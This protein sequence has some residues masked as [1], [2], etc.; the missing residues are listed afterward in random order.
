[1]SLI[2]DMLRNIEAK[3]PDDP[4]R[5]N[6]QR[7]I[8]SLPAAPSG[9][10]RWLKLLLL[11]GVPVLGAAVLHANGQL[12]PLLGLDTVQYVAPVPAV[13]PPP[14]PALAPTAVASPAVDAA[15]VAESDLRLASNLAILPLPAEP[16]LAVPDPIVPLAPTPLAKAEAVTA[17]A[18]VSSPVAASPAAPVGPVKIEKSPVLATPR[19][20]ADAEYRKAENALAAG[21]SA[22]AV[23]GLK[24]ALKQDPGYVQVRQM[25]LRQLLEMRKI[26]E[27]MTVLQD[28]L[29]LQPAQIGWAM[30]LARLQLEQH[31]VA[32]ADRT[33]AKSQVYA[34]ASADYAAFQG[35]VKSRLG[36]NRQAVTHYQRATRLAPNEGRWW[37]GLGLA[38]E[39]DGRITEAKEAMR[40]SIATATLSVELSA[41][42]EQHLR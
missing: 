36:V 16:V 10:G 11:I 34:E 38:L 14:P 9:A 19:D 32:A 26:E 37:L 4:A 31:D 29:E 35:H 25:L 13:V 42:A 5:Q 17:P 23:D 21:R 1:M 22:E 40:R 18:P 15:P 39:A 20:R 28:G 7:E 8:R 24:A 6:L 2:N 30:S 33:L 12:L 3:R 27:A 41:V